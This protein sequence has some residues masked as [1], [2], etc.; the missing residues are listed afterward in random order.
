[1]V[2]QQDRPYF[3]SGEKKFLINYAIGKGPYMVT[4]QASHPPD[5][6]AIKIPVIKSVSLD[7]VSH[8]PK[9][10]LNKIRKT[11]IT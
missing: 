9:N 1:M 6:G 8:S 4:Q 11:K 5:K 10:K 3:G 7:I 2:P